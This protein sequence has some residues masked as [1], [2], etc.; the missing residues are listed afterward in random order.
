MR[1]FFIEPLNNAKG[2]HIAVEDDRVTLTGEFS[3]CFRHNVSVMAKSVTVPTEMLRDQIQSLETSADSWCKS[4]R[5]REGKKEV[6]MNLFF[7]RFAHPPEAYVYFSFQD[8]NAC[9]HKDLV[10]VHRETLL[11]IL[12]GLI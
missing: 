12:H 10:I 1:K 7:L 6:A 5:F 11:E 4:M 3:P 8:G 9:K 2:L